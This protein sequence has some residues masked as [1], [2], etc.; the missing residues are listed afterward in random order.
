MRS[1][2]P[3]SAPCLTPL[4]AVA[5][6]AVA[7]VAGTAAMDV[8]QYVQYRVGGGQD[9]FFHWELG[10]VTGWEGAPAPAQVGKRVIEGLFRAE[11]PDE[12]ANRMNNAVHWAYGTGWGVVYGVLAGSTATP[13]LGWGPVFA[14]L[15]WLLDYVVL[16]PTG[17]YQPIWKYD[18]KVLA[19]D[20]ATRLVYG[21]T[22][23]TVL[24]ALR[25]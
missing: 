22:V 7:G 2:R 14:S 6:G 17:L 21:T 8:V 16:P 13:R 20:W 3:G 1:V 10:A 11:L 19:K 9:T 12:A 23:G 5:R 18:A 4:G 24:W 15:Q 25:S